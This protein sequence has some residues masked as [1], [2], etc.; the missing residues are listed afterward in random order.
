MYI[1]FVR[2]HG[3]KSYR[4]KTQ[5]LIEEREAAAAGAN[6]AA[7]LDYRETMFQRRKFRASHYT[8]FAKDA[9][10][11]AKLRRKEADRK[12]LERDAELA[13]RQAEQEESVRVSRAIEQV[14]GGVEI[15]PAR[16]RGGAGSTLVDVHTG[17]GPRF[18]TSYY[19]PIWQD[20][21]RVRGR[22]RGHTSL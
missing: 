2:I 12:F 16:W 11:E 9:R 1:K 10:L 13:A 4:E 8:Q 20:S 14:T 15:K 22:R 7:A 5:S 21:R 17:Q 3:F 6:T 18:N 19:F